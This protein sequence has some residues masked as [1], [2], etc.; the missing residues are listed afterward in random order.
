MT[1]DPHLRRLLEAIGTHGVSEQ[2][3]AWVQEQAPEMSRRTAVIMVSPRSFGVD[4]RT[5][6][7]PTS[8]EPGT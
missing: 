5:A 6:S 3:V 8:R 1:I 4:Y 2:M 7:A